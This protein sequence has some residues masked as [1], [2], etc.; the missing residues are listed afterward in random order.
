[1][2]RLQPAAARLADFSAGSRKLLDAADQGQ[3]LS[4][5]LDFMDGWVGVIS[6]ADG[7]GHVFRLRLTFDNE[8]FT[9]AIRRYLD[10]FGPKQRRS[11]KAQA[12]RTALEQVQRTLDAH[13]G[14]V[15][16]QVR[17]R[18]PQRVQELPDQV[19]KKLGD[20]LGG[21]TGS[22]PSAPST[23]DLAPLLHYMLGS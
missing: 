17:K 3:G 1:L 14:A 16:E 12:V 10:E 9:S 4:K 15:P 23:G 13:R 5:F 22:A 20:A 18:L 21:A 2:R 7:L 6:N 11:A 19:T 8:F